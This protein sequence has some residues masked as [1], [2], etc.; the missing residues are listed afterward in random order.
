MGNDG[1][2]KLYYRVSDFQPRADLKNSLGDL[3]NKMFAQMRHWGG[4][5]IKSALR[6][7]QG[8][9]SADRWCAMGGG[10]VPTPTPDAFFRPQ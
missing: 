9:C 1:P 3:K 4:V 8:Q 2:V 7:S 10:G 5:I 6:I